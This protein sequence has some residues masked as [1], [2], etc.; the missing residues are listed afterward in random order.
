M[1]NFYYIIMICCLAHM[2]C[3]THTNAIPQYYPENRADETALVLTYREPALLKDRYLCSTLRRNLASLNQKPL[4]EKKA[5]MMAWI[6]N[7]FPEY[8][9]ASSDSGAD[10]RED[11]WQYTW[12]LS[13]A[14]FDGAP[15]LDYVFYLREPGSTYP[16]TVSVIIQDSTG[17]AYQYF[18]G[19]RRGLANLLGDVKDKVRFLQ[20]SQINNNV[21]NDSSTAE[22]AL[23]V[24]NNVD[25]SKVYEPG[26]KEYKGTMAEITDLPVPYRFDGK[27]LI[28]DTSF[29]GRFYKKL[30]NSL[31]YAGPRH[32]FVLHRTVTQLLDRK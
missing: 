9:N 15:P 24:H 7:M 23:L 4:P 14:D 32:R 27:K 20:A 2:S 31:E 3:G 29:S 26:E 1:K 6:R 16:Y 25:F 10:S 8:L 5:D 30:V 11:L 28:W 13:R 19:T 21:I 17:P 18:Y 22:Q 12:Q